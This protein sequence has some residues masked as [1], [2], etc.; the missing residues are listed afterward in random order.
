MVQLRPAQFQELAL[1]GSE[2]SISGEVETSAMRFVGCPYGKTGC[3]SLN[4][5]CCDMAD[6]RKLQR[7]KLPQ[8]EDCFDLHSLRCAYQLSVY[9][10]QEM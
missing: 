2:E 1:L 9:G 4:A 10:D 3:K 5:L 7:K 8:T 6:H